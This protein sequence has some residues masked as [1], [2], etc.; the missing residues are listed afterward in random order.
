M[1]YNILFALAAIF[2]ILSVWNEV[3]KQ[4]DHH[5]FFDKVGT[6]MEAGGRNTAEHGYALCKRQE[7]LEAHYLEHDEIILDIQSCEEIYSINTVAK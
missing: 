2:L 6:F 5:A 7:L 3:D 1:K 4:Q